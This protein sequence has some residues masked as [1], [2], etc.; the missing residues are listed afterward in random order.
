[1][2][3]KT[4]VGRKKEI[5]LIRR[6]YDS[7]KSEMVAVYGR[8]RVGKTFLIKE[9]MGDFFDFEFVGMYKTPAKVQRDLFQKKLNSLSGDD[10]K[11]PRTGMRHLTDCLNT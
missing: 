5:E 8:R 1:M 4:L 7:P 11:R 2:V 3:V 10:K 9:T 6:Y